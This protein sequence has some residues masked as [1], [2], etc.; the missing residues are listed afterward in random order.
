M[1]S[2][3]LLSVHI[4]QMKMTLVVQKANQNVPETVQQDE[5]H[6]HARP[7]EGDGIPHELCEGSQGQL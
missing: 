7:Q 5:A 1:F 3:H 4:F 2:N 6:I